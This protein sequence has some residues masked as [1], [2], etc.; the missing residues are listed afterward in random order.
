ME[1]NSWSRAEAVLPPGEW[2]PDTN[3]VVPRAGLDSVH[4]KK[5]NPCLPAR[6]WR[7]LKGKVRK[8]SVSNGFLLA[9]A[10][11][12]WFPTAA[13]RVRDRVWSSGICVEQSGVGAGFLR[14]L[15]FPLPIF[16]PPKFSIITITRGRYNRPFS[17]WRAEWNQNGPHPPLYEYNKWFSLHSI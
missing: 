1:V 12:R 11:R 13:T 2:A 4:K 8:W 17:G 9:Q 3:W 15:R 7:R 14:V 6:N 16:I 5:K 10:V